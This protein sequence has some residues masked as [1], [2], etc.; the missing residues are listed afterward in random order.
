PRR[1]DEDAEPRVGSDLASIRP[2]EYLAARPS[3]LAL[4][5]SGVRPASLPVLRQA[6]GDRSGHDTQG[7]DRM[8]GR[9]WMAALTPGASALRGL[10]LGFGPPVASRAEDA[11]STAPSTTAPAPVPAESPSPPT[12]KV[13]LDLAIVGLGAK[14]CDIEVAPGHLGCQFRPVSLHLGNQ[15]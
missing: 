10:A 1:A 13:K 12:A 3:T 5:A 15:D 6:R 4:R 9:S 11:K 2:D 8:Q 7:V 14:G